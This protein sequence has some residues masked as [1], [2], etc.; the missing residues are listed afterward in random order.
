MTDGELILLASFLLGLMVLMGGLIGGWITFRVK[1]ALLASNQDVLGDKLK[2]IET[3]HLPSLV[4]HLKELPCQPHMEEIV[5]LTVV[6]DNS[7]KLQ[8]SITTRLEKLEGRLN[9]G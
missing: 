9:G 4:K 5:K 2:L 7:S 3:S 8:E 1:L 6:L